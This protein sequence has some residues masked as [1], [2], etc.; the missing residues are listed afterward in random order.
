MQDCLQSL[1]E[2]GPDAPEFDI[3]VVDN[4]SH[5]NSLELIGEGFP[6][7]KVMALPENTGFC[8]AVN[9]GIQAAETPYVILLNNDTRV[10]PGF[11]SGLIHAIERNPKIFSVSASMRMWDAPELLDG[12]GD[13]YCVLGWAYSRGKGRPADKYPQPREV[14]SACG[15]AA[16]YRRE[17]FEKIGLFDEAHFAYLEDLDIGWRARIYGYHNYYEPSARVIHFGSASTGSRYNEKKTSL[18]S[19]NSV[20]V[21]GKNMAALQLLL[22]LPFLITGFF[23]K[24]LFFCGKGMGKLYLKGLVEGGRKLLSPEGRG[25]KVRFRFSRLGNYLAI[26]WQLYLNLIRFLKK[27]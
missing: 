17:V 5:D 1:Q 14:F 22:N 27:S 18:A 2:Q 6:R 7:V 26:Q 13:R 20:Y 9:V 12:A 23:I 15:G 16:V 25:R 24:F 19:A 3:L 10:E 4:G 8:H 11:V 21:A